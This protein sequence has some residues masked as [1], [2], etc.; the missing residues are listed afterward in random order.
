MRVVSTSPMLERLR[1]FLNDLAPE[2]EA[3]FSGDDYRVAAAALFVHLVDADGIVAEAER[4][5]LHRIIRERFG[6]DGRDAERLLAEARARDA[7][8]VDL[9]RFTSVLKERLDHADRLRVIEAM[10]E[11]VFAD[12][13]VSELEDNTVWRVAELLGVESG[14]RIALKHRVAARVHPDA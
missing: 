5:T 7:E 9:Y 13:T 8:A 3:G 12:G 14:E 6:L 11:L 1:N 4:S 10:W 2:A